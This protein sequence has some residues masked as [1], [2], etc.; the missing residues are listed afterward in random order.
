[1]IRSAIVISMLLLSSLSMAFTVELSENELQEKVSA[2]MPLEKKKYFIT[3]IFTNPVVDLLE[4]KNKIGITLDIKVVA[5][6]GI[7]GQG[8]AKLSGSLR[9]DNKKAEFYLNDP[10]LHELVIDNITDNLNTKIKDLAQLS[11][12]KNLSTRPVYKLKDTNLKHQLAKS[13]LKSVKVEK[14]K[15]IIELSPF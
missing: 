9:Y 10:I 5:P 11:L 12:E 8:T 6:G 13:L 7:E 4:T 3:M 14:E 1:M 15:M 2:M